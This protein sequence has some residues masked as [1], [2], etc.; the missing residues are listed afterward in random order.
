MLTEIVCPNKLFFSK[1]VDFVILPG[2]EGDFGILNHHSPLISNLRS[3]LIYIYLENKIIN[4]FF[5]K[6][7]VCQISQ[8]KC[9]ILTERAEDTKDS[10]LSDE[11]IDDEEY[12]KLKKTIINNKYYN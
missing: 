5:I 10:D 11:K 7:G 3:G 12:L 2:A 1:D 6:Q 4:I 9:I 8:N